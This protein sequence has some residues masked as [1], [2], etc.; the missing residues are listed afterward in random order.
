MKRSIFFLLLI[1]FCVRA[2][3][4]TEGFAESIGTKI[5]YRSFGSGTPVLIINGGPGL[6]SDGFV[7]LA[8][9]L[10]DHNNT[11]IYDQR[12]TGKSTL[13]KTDTSTITMQLMVEDMENLRKHLHISKWIILGHSFGGMM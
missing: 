13:Q 4:Q 9:L 7:G 8:K 5:Y 12:G 6:N 10:S 3:S 11:I 2:E 1:I